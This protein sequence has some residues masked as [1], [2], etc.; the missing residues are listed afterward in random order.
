MQI[1]LSNESHRGLGH[2]L[3]TGLTEV[4]A[5]ETAG[6]YPKGLKS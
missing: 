3:S 1:W 4:H 5:T 6:N 2:K